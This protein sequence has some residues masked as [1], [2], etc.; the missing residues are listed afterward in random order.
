MTSPETARFTLAG[1]V[2]SAPPRC[3][4]KF[5]LP[6]VDAGKFRAILDVNCRRVRYARATS[7]I[8]SIYF[9]DAALSACRANFDGTPRR[10]KTRIRWYDT[11]FPEKRFF[12]EVKRREDQG[13]IKER[14][15]IQASTPLD[16]TPFHAIVSSL[17]C[18]LPERQWEIFMARCEAKVMIEYERA[19]F[20]AR[21][22]PV[23]ITLD[24]DLVFWS[25]D[26]KSSPDRRFGTPVAGLTILE[27]KAP[28]GH[29][30]DIRRLLHPLTPWVTRSSKYVL[31]CQRLGLL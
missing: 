26:G 5:S 23:R 1:E 22:A 7:R 8:C 31:A 16:T 12:F 19:Y 18:A 4:V 29:E 25:Q 10:T 17:G 21:D 11:P 14:A 30:E 20:E 24:R 13:I 9:D 28:F 6:N 15:P 3:E 27:G 2:T